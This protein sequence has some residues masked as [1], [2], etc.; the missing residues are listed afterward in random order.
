MLLRASKALSPRNALLLTRAR[1]AAAPHHPPRRMPAFASASG[2]EPEPP[3]SVRQAAPAPTPAPA[4]GGVRLVRVESREG[5]WESGVAA[6]DNGEESPQEAAQRVILLAAGDVASLLLFA[7]AGRSSHAETLMLFDVLSTAAPFLAAWALAAPLV[8]A[9][10]EVARGGD[11]RSALGAALRA[12]AVAVPSGLA[13]RSLSQGGRL[14]PL[15]FV[16]VTLGATAVLLLGWRAGVAAAA[17]KR[18]RVASS[19]ANKKGGILDFLQLLSGL[20]KRW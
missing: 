7:A 10:G 9:Y 4:S 13:L 20:T 5:A 19:R 6:R 2:S 14:P 15:P 12:W 17:P 18:D 16:A 11:V 8:G 1:Q 3:A